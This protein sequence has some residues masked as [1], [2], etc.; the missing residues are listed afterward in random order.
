MRILNTAIILPVLSVA[1]FNL[2]GCQNEPS[3]L[4]PCFS[5]NAV[6]GV[7]APEAIQADAYEE[8]A[9]RI[10]HKGSSLNQLRIFIPV[11]NTTGQL[12]DNVKWDRFAVMYRDPDGQ[13]DDYHVRAR[14]FYLDGTGGTPNV[15]ELDSNMESSTDINT[16]SKAFNHGFDFVNRYYYVE[17]KINRKNTNGGPWIGGVKLC[18]QFQ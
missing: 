2:A 17:I 4:N 3:N 16:M 1:F 9:G 18:E 6:A 13:A 10:R 15:A 8:A 12:G 14:L 5:V 11:I 7:P